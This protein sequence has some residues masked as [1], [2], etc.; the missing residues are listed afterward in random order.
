MR[1]A[2]LDMSDRLTI[3]HQFS[4]VSLTSND[5][6]RLAASVLAGSTMRPRS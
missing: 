3:R 5:W 4:Q 6:L 2:E 1:D